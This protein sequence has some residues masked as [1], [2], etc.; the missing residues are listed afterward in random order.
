MRKELLHIW[1]D[2]ITLTMVLLLPALLLLLLGYGISFEQQSVKLAVTDFSKTDSSR[3]L[4]EKFTVS[5][6]FVYEYD[7]LSE[8]A[9]V[10]LI[11]QDKVDVG[12]LI[13]EDYDRDLISGTESKILI[14]IDGS[15]QPT[16]SLTL[17]LKL[18]S[19]SSMAAQDNLIEKVEKSGLA[20]SFNLPFTGVLKTL[21][22]PN[23]DTKLYMIPGLV[24]ILLQIQ[25]LILSALSIVKEREQGTMEQLIVTPIRSWELMLGKIIPY[26]FV[27]IFTLF[28]LL[29]LSHLFFG[30]SVAGN[31]GALVGLSVI[32]ILGSLGLGVLISNI[33]QTQMQAIYILLFVILVPAII[34]SGLMFSR[35]SMPVFTYWY[36]ELLPVTQ[37]LEIIKGIMVRGISADSL[38]MSSTLPLIIL[39]V[40]Y[41]SASILVFRKRI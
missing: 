10:D 39:S 17:Q 3:K 16:D 30:V 9:L 20:S 13:P 2:P 12:I 41:F 21:Y 37:Y 19:I 29:G 4:I 34:L 38:F 25:T 27:C 23:G 31:L 35:D 32:Y 14:Y 18:N 24:A 33:S 36:S 8:D 40:V 26:L 6:D 11:D 15:I 5:Q 28:A 7:V 22:N 1:R